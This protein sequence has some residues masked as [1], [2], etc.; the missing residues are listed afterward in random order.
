MSRFILP[1]QSAYDSNGKPLNG[2]KLYFY[3]VGTST[4]KDTYSDEAL[5]TANTNPV[6]ADASGG[7]GDIYLS[8]KYD[9]TLKNSADV[10]IWGA[11]KTS[12]L[13]I[14]GDSILSFDTVADMVASKIL[15]VGDIVETAGYT[16]VNDGGGAKYEIVAADTGTDDGGSFIDLDTYQAKAMFNGRPNAKQFGA[17]GDGATDDSTSISSADSYGDFELI[18]GTFVIGANT[19]LSSDVTIYPDA[20]FKVSSGINLTMSGVVNAGQYQ[21]FDADGST[22]GTILGNMKGVQTWGEWWGALPDVT[23]GV[24]DELNAALQH[25]SQRD[26]GGI[27]YR[28][29]GFQYLDKKIL[30]PEKCGIIGVSY[31]DSRYILKAGVDLGAGNYLFE[32]ETKTGSGQEFMYLEKLTIVGNRSNASVGGGILGQQVFINSSLSDLVVQGFSGNNIHLAASPNLSSLGEGGP[33]E[34]RNVWS[35]DCSGNALRVEGDFKGVNIRGGAY[36]RVDAGSNVI[37]ID[38]SLYNGTRATVR[39]YSTHL[40]F[41]NANVIGIYVKKSLVE[42][43]GGESVGNQLAT[44]KNIYVEDD[45]TSVVTVKNFQQSVGTREGIVL[46]NSGET[47]NNNYVGHFTTERVSTTVAHESNGTSGTDITLDMKWN[48]RVALSAGSATS[49]ADIS[50]APYD[51]IALRFATGNYTV[52]HNSNIQLA[53]GAD[54]VMTSGDLLILARFGSVFYE[55]KGT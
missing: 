55:I 28:G 30:I 52:R 3:E 45:G 2:A 42:V 27:L 49:I 26:N 16:T 36:E 12:S 53:S 18:G 39:C 38:G 34:I 50:N 33:V 40:E 31:N 22:T 14:L 1:I 21:I 10:T 13:S 5:T 43:Y 23:D 41:S 6:I 54:H 47:N 17:K 7:F 44:Q 11:E 4:P 46:N 8:G 35:F 9:V 25:L 19:T 29:T 24:S 51:L 32:N 15:N 48:N 20:I 37:H